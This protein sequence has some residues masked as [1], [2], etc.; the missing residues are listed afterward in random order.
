M[1]KP[2]TI[3]G[4]AQTNINGLKFERNTSLLADIQKTKRYRVTFGCD[5]NPRFTPAKRR[6]YATR[7][8]CGQ[9][10]DL[11]SG[12]RIAQYFEQD[13]LYT[14]FLEING[15]NYKDFNSYKLKPDG[16]LIIGN[17]AIIIEK[18]FQSGTGSVDEKL[19]TCDFKKKQYEKL[20]GPIGFEVRYIY[21]LN[22]WFNQP[23]FDDVFKYIP[24]VG[25]E[26]FI[27]VL[28]LK[29]VGL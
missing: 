4:G 12:K 25:C 11:K 17:T 15:V 13:V 29:A 26:Y 8:T 10:F 5:Q 24:S 23:K 19:Q 16:C 14:Q 21:L 6:D 28:P 20:F 9:V 22:G 18:K 2:N 7:K 1:R 27:D 3:G